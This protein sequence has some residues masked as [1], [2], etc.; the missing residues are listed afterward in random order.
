MCSHLQRPERGVGNSQSC[1]YTEAVSCQMLVLGTE[2]WSSGR[3]GASA[4]NFWTLCPALMVESSLA[5]ERHHTSV[6]VKAL[7]IIEI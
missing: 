6:A 2:L 7:G 4:L 1:N 5:F 3:A